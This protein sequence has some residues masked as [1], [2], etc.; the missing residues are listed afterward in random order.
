MKQGKRSRSYKIK[1]REEFIEL[2][3]KWYSKLSKT[4]FVDLEWLDKNSGYGQNSPFLRTSLS[5][6]K[7]LSP[8]ELKNHSEY[9]IGATQFLEDYKF[10]SALHK[11]VWQ[12]YCDG[13]SYRDML[14]KIASRNFKKQPSIFWISIELNK[15]KK[16]YELWQLQQP[17]EPESLA[18]FIEDND[19][20]F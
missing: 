10:P 3:N 15:L 8:S 16:A 20:I 19:S 1:S 9:F 5:K 12:C 17:E 4:G 13:V 11:F 7:H 18:K 6:F 2:Q 14:P